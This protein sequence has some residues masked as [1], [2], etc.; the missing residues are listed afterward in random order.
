MLPLHP[1]VLQGARASRTSA[2][3]TRTSS[4]L[5]RDRRLLGRGHRRGRPNGERVA[6]RGALQR[7]DED[8]KWILGLL[9]RDLF[10]GR[11]LEAGDRACECLHHAFDLAGSGA[12][13]LQETGVSGGRPDNTAIQGRLGAELDVAAGYEA[14]RVCALRALATVREELGTLDGVKRIV[15]LYGV[16][17]AT[18]DFMQH[19]Q[20]MN[21]A[22]DLLVELFG[23]AGKHARLAVGVSS[24]PFNIA[25]EIELTIEVIN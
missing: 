20:V 3:T 8:L 17:N 10:H 12:S 15:K 1:R 2:R 21:G 14:A 24:L 4:L 7:R 11:K 13:A 18:S 23:D 25:L 22:S 16:V 19:T 5:S 9:R 6:G